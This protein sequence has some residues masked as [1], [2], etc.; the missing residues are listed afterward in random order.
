[1]V[2]DFVE[3]H[4]VFWNF[5]LP[6]LLR[7]K[8]KY[9]NI[10]PGTRR[11]LEYGAEKE[12]WTSDRFMEQMKNAAVIADVKYRA[13]HTIVWLFDQSSCHK[14]YAD[15]ASKILVK[16]GGPWKVKDTIW[17]GDHSPW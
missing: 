9:P 14:K 10:E 13:T 8:G 4:G 17:G 15:D 6:S 7:Q 12:Y 1:M 11:L 3:E 2:S 16:D 5:H